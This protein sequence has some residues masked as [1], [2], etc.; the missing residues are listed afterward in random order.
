M[1]E[2]DIRGVAKE[3]LI[4]EIQG[5][6]VVGDRSEVVIGGVHGNPGTANAHLSP[7][8]RGLLLATGEDQTPNQSSWDS[9]CPHERNEEAAPT[10]ATRFPQ[11]KSRQSVGGSLEGAKA[12]S[13]DMIK[14]GS[15]VL[16]QTAILRNETP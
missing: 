8:V 15:D 7:L 14:S 16:K 10:V 9:L 13:L 2:S 3:H 5:Q 12:Q 1:R 11:A 6:V 4:A